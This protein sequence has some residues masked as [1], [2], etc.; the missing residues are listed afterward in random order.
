MI[1]IPLIEVNGCMTV[2]QPIPEN[3]IRIYYGA[4]EATV[5]VEGD[6]VPPEPV[7]EVA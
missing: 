6:V 5:Y 7:Y 1:T 3:A 4:A 2:S